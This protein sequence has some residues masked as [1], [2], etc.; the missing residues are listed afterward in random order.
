MKRSILLL[1]IVLMGIVAPAQQSLTLEACEALFQKNNLQLLAEQYNI[2]AARA[3][4][5]Q[6][7]VWEQ[8]YLSGELNAINPGANR[9]FDIGAT[10]QKSAAVQQ[11]IYMG[12]KKRNEI[13]FSRSNVVLAELQF[14]QLLRDLKFQLRQNFYSLYFDEQNISRLNEQ[15]AKVD[16]L[17]DAYAIQAA[18][19]NVSLKDVVRLQALSLTFKNELVAF[20]KN[21][22]SEREALLLLTGIT[23]PIIPKVDSTALEQYGRKNLSYSMEQL[24]DKAREANPDYRYAAELAR[25]SD[26]MLRW[27]KSL[28]VPDLTLGGSY[29]QRGGAFN[30]QVNLTLGMPLPLWSRNKGNIKMARAQLD[31]NKTSLSYKELE[32]TTQIRTAWSN[33]Q[34]QQIQYLQISVQSRNNFTSVYEGILQNF[35]KRNI[36]LLDFTDFMESY[37]QSILAL[38]SLQKELILSAETLNYLVNEK[39]F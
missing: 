12:G 8:P 35:Q 15:V 11:L 29:D 18:R 33:W 13:A 2:T 26:L 3:S 23:D 31:Q 4:V 38:S 17:A 37:N 39:I 22:N 14:E 21:L 32:L 25:N 16:E 1:S 30:N 34:Q 19:N 7:R 6:A 27:Q 20:R 24:F 5:I 28:S 9:F 36:S 10:G